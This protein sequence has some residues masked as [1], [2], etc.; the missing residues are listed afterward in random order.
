[1]DSREGG[2]QSDFASLAVRRK[3]ADSWS[4]PQR[5]GARGRIKGTTPAGE[6]PPAV[7]GCLAY[8]MPRRDEGARL[9]AARSSLTRRCQLREMKSEA[10]KRRNKA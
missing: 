2:P 4:G 6:T 10:T 1:M 7:T 8:G 3:S 9:L 5:K